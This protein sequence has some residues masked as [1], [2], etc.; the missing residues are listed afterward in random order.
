MKHTQF[1]EHLL[2]S[3]CDRKMKDEIKSLSL[4]LIIVEIKY[5]QFSDS[6]KMAE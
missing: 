6:V 3:Y 5:I 2:N 4:N 1:H